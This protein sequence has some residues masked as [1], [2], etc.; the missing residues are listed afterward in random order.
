M[1]ESL[2]SEFGYFSNGEVRSSKDGDF[3]TSP[4]VSNYFGVFVSK[5]LISNN[6]DNDS[7]I[8]EIG[9]GTGSLAKH[10]LLYTSPSP[11]DL[12]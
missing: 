3:L 10:C 8:L 5:W 12:H 2:Y 6:L 9:A 11:R 7:N 4:E 1:E